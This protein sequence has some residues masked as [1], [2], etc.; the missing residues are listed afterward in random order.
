MKYFRNSW[1]L[2]SSDFPLEVHYG[3]NMCSQLGNFAGSRRIRRALPLALGC[4]ARRETR[5]TRRCSNPNS[6]GIK[7]DCC[8]WTLL[9]HF[10]SSGLLSTL[11][12]FHNFISDFPIQHAFALL[13]QH[14]NSFL[15]P[16][17]L[18]LDSS[19]TCPLFGLPQSS[20]HP[21]ICDDDSWDLTPL[22]SGTG[23]TTP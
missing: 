4:P 5:A 18:S 2:R 14:C 19:L 23:G 13:V 20:I 11:L 17:S 9:Q 21:L 12:S 3:H 6:I 22:F 16:P 1:L 10:S 7:R 8:T 15:L